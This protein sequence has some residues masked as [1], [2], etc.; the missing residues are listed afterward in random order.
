MVFY[1]MA[2][3]ALGKIFLPQYPI[4]VPINRSLFSFVGRNH[5]SIKLDTSIAQ[6]TLYIIDDLVAEALGEH[7]LDTK[8]CQLE[9]EFASGL[10]NTAQAI[11]GEIIS[12]ILRDVGQLV[13]ELESSTGHT[14][15]PS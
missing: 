8:G 12:A 14:H 15:H 13:S 10:C 7:V 5:T 1:P 11:G 3:G 4:Y 2:V 9:I 6:G